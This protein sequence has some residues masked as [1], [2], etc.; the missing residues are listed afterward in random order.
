MKTQPARLLSLKDSVAVLDRFMTSNIAKAQMQPQIPQVIFQY[1]DHDPPDQIISLL[2][3]NRFLCQKNNVEYIFFNDISARHCIK[4][5]FSEDIYRAYDIAPHP[6]MKCDLFRLCYLYQYGGFYLDADM[7]L[8]EKFYELFSI[9]GELAVFKWDIE[10][11]TNICNWLIG[12]EANSQIIKFTLDATTRSILAACLADT[13]KALKN[14]LSVSGP[15]IFTRAVSTFIAQKE[16]Q[17][18]EFNAL[19]YSLESVTFAFSLVQNGPKFLKKPLKYKKT[20]LHWLIAAN[21][22]AEI[23]EEKRSDL[24]TD[25]SHGIG[26]LWKKIRLIVQNK[27]EN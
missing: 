16:N 6:A 22:P 20:K 27:D 9:K 5:H 13:D 11:R 14:I 2:D 18:A 10:N 17:Q 19:P 23:I 25:D 3:R 15:G 4:D 24:F 21:E 1:W 26:K 7:V 12:S 8:T